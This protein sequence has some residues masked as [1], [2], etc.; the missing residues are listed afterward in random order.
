[1]LSRF[2][3]PGGRISSTDVPLLH[4]AWA[5]LKH[6]NFRKTNGAIVVALT[7]LA[8]IGARQTYEDQL[9]DIMIGFEAFFLPK[10]SDAELNFRLALNAAYLLKKIYPESPAE[11]HFRFIKKAYGFRGSIVH[12]TQP[13]EIKYRGIDGSVIGPAA[14]IQYTANVLRSCV[15]WAIENW[16]PGDDIVIDWEN[17]VYFLKS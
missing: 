8:G 4:R 5:H 1:M 11:Q 12:G 9:V 13:G 17:D 15:A 14:Y 3:A 16:N 6:P 2:D 7:R 10:G